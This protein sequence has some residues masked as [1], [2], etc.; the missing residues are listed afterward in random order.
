MRFVFSK[1]FYL[2]F[3][4]G[5]VVLSFSWGRPSLRWAALA[6]DIALIIL[7]IVDAR[8]SQ[9]PK[10]VQIIRTFSGRFAV[11]AETEVS[12]NIRNLQPHATTLVI[13]DE[14]PPRMKL[15]GLREAK[16]RIEARRSAALVYGVTPSRRGLFEFGHIA[17]RFLSRLNLVWCQ[18]NVGAPT[19]VK[20]YPNMR[21]AREAELKA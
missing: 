5:L 16:I 9:L 20:V 3:A 18:T 19:S 8:R 14:Y 15:S 13:K 2:L 4:G 11:G 6:Y 17:V 10:D 1:F 12:V 21:R 7:A